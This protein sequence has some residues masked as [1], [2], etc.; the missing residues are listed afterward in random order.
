MRVSLLQIF[1]VVS[2]LSYAL[3]GKAA[4]QEILDKKVSL[5]LPSREIRAV[6]KAIAASTEIGFTYSNDVLRNRQKITVIANDERLGDLLQR[7]FGPLHI[8]FEVIGHQIVLKKEPATQAAANGPDVAPAFKPITGTVAGADGAPLT[9]VSITVVGTSRGTTTDAQGHFSIDAKDGDILVFS[10]IGFDTYRATVG[11]AADLHITL[12]KSEHSMNEVVVTALGIKREAKSLGYSAQQVSGNDVV[13]ADAPDISNGL[14]G[15]VAGL[16]I[17]EPNGVEGSSSRIVIRG[18]NSLLGNN[19]PLIVVD[20]VMIDN[21]PILP[22]GQSITLQNLQGQNT[23]LSQNQA[24]DYGSFLN[25]LN[26]D[27]IETFDILKGP[28]AAA[29]YGARGANG[30]ILIT[31]KKGSKQK[32]LGI[33]YN[34]ADRWNQPYRF[35]KLQHEY[36]MGMADALY[37]ANPG[38]YTTSGGAPRETNSNDFYGS[39][40]TIPGG[41]NWWNYIGFPGDGASWGQKM[42]GQQIQWWDGTVRPYTGNPNI[43]KS[44]YKTGNTMTHNVSFSGGGDVGTVRV[45]YTRTDNDAITYSS[46]FHQNVFNV[47]SSI[48]VSKRVKVEATAS[49]LNLVRVNVPNVY[50]ESSASSGVGYITDYMIPMDYKPLEKGLAVNKDGSQNQTVISQSPS[51]DN[52]APGYYWWNTLVNNTTF[53]QNQ[54]LGSVKLIADI[55]PWLN[56]T[57]HTGLDYYTNEFVTKN[58]PVDAAGLTG[59]GGENLYSHDLSTVGV[60]NLD[61]LLTIHKDK[62][63]PGFNASLTGGASYYHNKLYDISAANPGPFNAPFTYTL[64]NYAGTNPAVLNPTENFQESEINSVY[65]ILNLSYKDYLF[66]EGS[67]RN[68]WS[69]TLPSDKWSFFYPSANLSFVFTNAL[70]MGSIGNWLSYGKVRVAE[71][72][73][74]N[75]YIP[76]QTEF[77]Y[78][79]VTQAGF[80]TGLSVPTTL[81]SISIQPQRARSFE[82]GADLGFLNNRINLNFT[83]YDIYSDHQILPVNIATSAGSDRLTINTGALRNRGIEFIINAKVFS[84]KDF[85]WDIAVN[86]GHNSNTIVALEPGVTQI[87]IG[88]WFGGDGISTNAHVGDQYGTIYGLD[89]QYIGKQKVVNLIY[90]DGMNTGN[91]PVLGAQY[92]TTPGVVKIGNST[93]KLTGGIG[94]TFRYKAFSLYVLTDFHFG[95]QIWSG[96]YSSLMG[97]G[98]LPETTRERDGHGLPFV[99]PDGS[100]G[101]VG[102]IL[103]GVTPDGKPNTAV[104]NSW[105]KYAG[106]FQSWDN[107]PVVRTNSIFTN[108]WAK[109]REVALTY[110]FPASLTNATGIFQNLSVSLIGRDLFYLFTR[111]PDRLNPEGL[112]GTTNNQSTQFGELPGTRS[113]GLSVKAGF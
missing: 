21:E 112:T 56:F 101:N 103:P 66:F 47:G 49:Y 63:F 10:S 18:N 95:G 113:F 75:G 45:S 7:I 84:K 4:G 60:Q 11:A 33:D 90:S 110:K 36:G 69:S 2:Y 37:S 88:S 38:F 76:Y 67:G 105:W 3:P 85:T 79:P 24:V 82:T 80:T 61:A 73:S 32:G 51:Q 42:E 20:G 35:I 74:A 9:G 27:D 106:N 71:A 30:V 99:F 58:R 62:L 14:I 52:G 54:L 25:T 111:L 40:S 12:Q 57:G 8:S 29:L 28:T 17:T 39:R 64:S 44:F 16:N 41:G 70:K 59:Y 96:D 86:G 104:V 53:T 83:Y 55:T 81:P 50:G 15:K 68:D 93:P 6:L 91:G 78:S 102:V 87:P 34:F 100:T 89:Y 26:A 65:G 48:N 1:L 72:A 23:D 107:I 19:Q 13:K 92:A 5:N 108:S 94:N 109:L 97:Q 77:V 98:E 31:T 22:Q 46:N 43:F